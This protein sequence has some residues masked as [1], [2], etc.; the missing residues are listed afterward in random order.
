[1]AD[2][3]GMAA[4]APDWHAIATLVAR[5]FHTGCTADGHDAAQQPEI[6]R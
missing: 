1:M 3:D 4:F 2:A 5:G 6:V